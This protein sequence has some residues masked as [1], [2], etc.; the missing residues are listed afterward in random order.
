[1]PHLERRFYPTNDA[2]DLTSAQWVAIAPL[3]TVTS[4][5]GGRPTDIALRTIVNALRSKQGTTRQWHLLP[6]D[7]PP[8][9]S[10]RSAFKT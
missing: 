10:V 4:P 7:V 3:V 6:A 1:M 8:M 2:T 9:S 5:K